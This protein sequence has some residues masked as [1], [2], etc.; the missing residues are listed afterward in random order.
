M[1]N[2]GSF[3]LI[4][5]LTVVMLVISIPQFG[6]AQTV[7][8]E[9]IENTLETVEKATAGN[10]ISTQNTTGSAANNPPQQDFQIED[11]T[12]NMDNATKS[13]ATNATEGTESAIASFG[14]TT[15][16]SA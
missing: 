11:I 4:L 6:Y 12:T 15:Q 14:E 7:E 1:K 3:L 2:N 9:I 8:N 5:F 16:E 13:A 10:E